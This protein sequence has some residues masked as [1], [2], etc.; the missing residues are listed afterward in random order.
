MGIASLNTSYG[1]RL[2]Q[3]SLRP[4]ARY[5][6]MQNPVALGQGCAVFVVAADQPYRG[7]VAAQAAVRHGFV[8]D[9]DRPLLADFCLSSPAAIRS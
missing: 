8:A 6:V 2:A 4:G 5:A 1:A 3:A 7:N 9:D